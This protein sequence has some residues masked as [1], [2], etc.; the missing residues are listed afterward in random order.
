M[1]IQVTATHALQDIVS[2]VLVVGAARVK[3]RPGLQNVVLAQ[4]AQSVDGLLDGLLTTIS[5]AGEF[6][7]NLGEMATIYTMGRLSAKRLLL[8]GLGK[9]E[10][11]DAQAVRRASATAARH[12]QI[13]GQTPSSW[14]LM[15][16]RLR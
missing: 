12:A 10:K 2:D 1:N 6:K 7:G 8:L 15:R 9:Q 5:A 16:I 13:R 3:G 4:S 11:V 14:P